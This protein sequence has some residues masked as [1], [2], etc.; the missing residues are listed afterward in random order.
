[1]YCCRQGAVRFGTVNLGKCEILIRLT[2]FDLTDQDR[3]A[4]GFRRN[5]AGRIRWLEKIGKFSTKI[6]YIFISGISGLLF[7]IL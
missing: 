2:L 3:R 6:Q 5:L 7:L 4:P 1:M